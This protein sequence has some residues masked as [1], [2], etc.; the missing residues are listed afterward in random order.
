LNVLKEK[1]VKSIVDSFIRC[2]YSVVMARPLRIEFPGAVYHVMNRGEA[3]RQ[4]FRDQED[5]QE[6]VK[7]LSE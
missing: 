4:V 3:Q 5:Y 7:V 6:F 2:F 1:G